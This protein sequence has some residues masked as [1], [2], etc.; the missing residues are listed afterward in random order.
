[1]KTQSA[2]SMA[3]VIRLCI[4]NSGK[5]SIQ[6]YGLQQRDIRLIPSNYDQTRIV[7]PD[8]IKRTANERL[9]LMDDIPTDERFNEIMSASI[10]G[11][12]VLT[13]EIINLSTVSD[14]IEHIITSFI[15][16]ILISITIID[17]GYDV[18]KMGTQFIMSQ[19]KMD[20]KD[21]EKFQLP[22]KNVLPFNLGQG[23]ITGSVVRGFTR[24]LTIDTIRESQCE[25]AAL[26][27]A[28]VLGL[29]CFAYRPNAYEA[30]VLVAES[31]TKQGN[32][33]DAS[34]MP[35]TNQDVVIDNLLT[36]SGI[37][38][39]LIWL[40]A[41][42]VIEY[43]NHPQLIVSDPREASGFLQRLE[44]YYGSNDPRL[45]WI[46]EINNTSNNGNSNNQTQKDKILK[47]AYIEAD[48]LVRNNKQYVYELSDRLASGAATIGDCIAVIEGW[49]QK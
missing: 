32:N 35:K 22:E 46:N 8:G 41:P 21:K 9:L 47:W 26:Y 14:S 29:P 49:E 18:I 2:L 37:L 10:F 43:M 1:V 24:L 25:A 28:Y 13:S 16:T 4:R 33:N 27:T 3:Q 31:A 12:T 34:T 38:R 36:S 17:N 23:M 11:G 6:Q 45:F 48:V 5:Y 42:V 44:D 15:L 39:I 30:S 19:I 7:C 20:N 40:Y